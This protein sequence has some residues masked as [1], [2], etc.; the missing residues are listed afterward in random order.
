MG[1]SWGILSLALW[2][3]INL[4]HAADVTV[5]CELGGQTTGWDQP[6]PA[7]SQ[8]HV[9]LTSSTSLEQVFGY[10]LELNYDPALLTAVDADPNI[11][12]QSQWQAAGS[13]AGVS[14]GGDDYTT[15]LDGQPVLLSTPGQAIVSVAITLPVDSQPVYPWHHLIAQVAFVAEQ[16]I[17]G[18]TPIDFA[19][20]VLRGGV[21]GTGNQAATVQFVK[22]CGLS[23]DLNHD[24]TVYWDDF[25]VFVAQWL[26]SG[27]GLV[28]D[29]NYD[30]QVNWA[31]FSIFAG[32]W[33]V[34]CP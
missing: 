19:V 24:G 4:C 8:F 23:A 13:P 14:F 20:N 34:S 2:L 16:D 15:Y 26:T 33:L 31:D 10:M 22:S 25:D 28:A 30:Q 6:I 18:P 27:R 12:T 29:L 32:Q 5:F 7:G 3:G 11:D 9:T 1:R 21:I 17:T